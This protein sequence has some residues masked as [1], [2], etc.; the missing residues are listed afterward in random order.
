MPLRQLY[1]DPENTAEDE[2]LVDIVAV[3]G[4][5]PRSKPDQEHAWDTWRTPAGPE[6]KLWLRDEL[7][8]EL[9]HARIFLYEYNS[10]AVYGKDR[11]TFLDKVNAFLE[12]MRIDRRKTPQRPLLLLGHSLGGLLIK[13]ALINAHNNEKYQDIKLA[14]QGLAFF[15]TPHDG[16][17]QSLVN[18]GQIAAKIALNLGFQRGDNILETLREG[19]MFSDLMH[20]HW[21]QRLLEYPI[22]SFWGTLDNIVPRESTSFGL[23]GKHENVVSLQASH[24]G[25]CKF[26]TSLQ[27][28]DNFKLVQANIQD[29]YDGAIENDDFEDQKSAAG[30]LC[31]LLRQ[32]FREK[33]AL[34]QD[35]ILAQYGEDGDKLLQS[36][37]ELWRILVSITTHHGSGQIVCILDALDECEE[38]DRRLLV[39]TLNDF[40]LA[41]G[42]NANLK[43]LTKL[44]MIHLRGEGPS[45]S[46]KIAK[47]IDLVVGARITQLCEKLRLTEGEENVMKR[48]MTQN[49]NRT[50]LWVYLVFEVLEACAGHSSTQIEAH[51]RNIPPTVD[52]AYEKILSRSPDKKKARKLLHMV[53]AAKRPLKLKE[54]AV[55]MTIQRNH[56][57]YSQLNIEPEERLRIW[58]REL[59]GLFVSIVDDKVYLLHQTAAEF[60]VER[61]GD[62]DAQGALLDEDNS[63]SEWKCSISPESSNLIL[64]S[65]CAQLL[66]FTDIVDDVGKHLDADLEITTMSLKI[67]DRNFPFFHY[68]VDHWNLHLGD[69]SRTK[70]LPSSNMLQLCSG[71]ETACFVQIPKLWGHIR[72]YKHATA[73]T[74]LATAS[75]LRL[76]PITRH[77]LELEPTNVNKRDPILKLS[78][79]SWAVLGGRRTVFDMFIEAEDDYQKTVH[80]LKRLLG[81]SYVD[82]DARNYSAPDTWPDTPLKGPDTPL[83]WAVYLG[84]EYIVKKLLETGRVMVKKEML[85]GA[86][87]E[88]REDIL[89]ALLK[90]GRVRVRCK[91]EDGRRLLSWAI[92]HGAVRVTKY[93]LETGKFDMKK[94]TQPWANELSGLAYAAKH[95]ADDLLRLLLATGQ[96]D[97][98]LR[99][100]ASGGRTAISFAAEAGAQECI[101][102][103]L[104]AGNVEVDA[105]DLYMRTPLCYAAR[106]GHEGVVRQLLATGEAVVDAGDKYNR[107][108]LSYAAEAG[109]EEIA[110]Q[111]LARKADIN[112]GDP[113]GRTPFLYAIR[114]GRERF[115]VD[116]LDVGDVDVNTRDLDG[117]TPLSYAI[118]YGLEGVVRQLLATGKV[119]VNVS[120]WDGY[121][122]LRIAIVLKRLDIVKA[123]L[124]TRDIIIRPEY[125]DFEWEW[126]RRGHVFDR[127]DVEQFTKVLKA[128]EA[129]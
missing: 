106:G 89:K 115:V 21:K 26:G 12:A 53:V 76:A 37:R 99:N 20:E 117:Y 94:E 44:P 85:F 33:P 110:R 67:L 111:L 114:S 86:A 102:L 1:P 79:L 71:S 125:L 34:L 8:K 96:A 105:M 69:V 107:T 100:D 16:G 128:Y 127:N 63:R 74:P 98:N 2:A 61:T 43:F 7:P 68:S 48:E 40:Y 56:T 19:S 95:G 18:I 54:M 3:H 84:E 109:H 108:P 126:E 80:P 17:R 101:R 30:A 78:P 25:V 62:E 112:A 123:L 88:D 15:A 51:I 5:N 82:F 119:D 41:K 32:I 49:P 97:I 45:E 120:T 58:V 116:L 122:P 64:G 59:C 10:T 27:D 92:S 70:D 57:S 22:V 72:P 46:E 28:R 118:S 124:E 52:D 121:S 87:M 31:C 9:P 47:E 42:T 24:G 11:T 113:S 73:L 38:Q 23:P 36:F 55:A 13:Q 129:E 75:I 39:E 81:R 35:S 6:G 104:A 4:L 65:V 93:L 103:L 29:L 77:L 83:G 91:A 14:T 66:L 50:Y 60:L 90:T